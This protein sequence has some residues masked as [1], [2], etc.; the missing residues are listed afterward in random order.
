MH[1]A[2]YVYLD[3]LVPLPIRIFYI[4]SFH[5]LGSLLSYCTLNCNLMRNIYIYNA[6]IS[7]FIYIC[8]IFNILR[9]IKYGFTEIDF[10]LAYRACFWIKKAFIK[11]FIYAPYCDHR[12]EHQCHVKTRTL[13]YFMHY[14]GRGL[15]LN[16]LRHID[17]FI[18]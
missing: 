10:P 6:Y 18:G 7:L 11:S 12:D 4:C 14:E 5:Y 16:Q 13:P 17:V 8:L 2:G 15:L 9:S 3:H 1:E